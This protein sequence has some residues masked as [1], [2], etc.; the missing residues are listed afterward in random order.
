MDALGMV[1]SIWNNNTAPGQRQFS[2]RSD[3][4]DCESPLSMY[5]SSCSM[6]LRPLLHATVVLAQHSALSLEVL[7]RP[8]PVRPIYNEHSIHTGVLVLPTV[9]CISPYYNL[10]QD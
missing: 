3:V 5:P 9:L 7:I 8:G 2:Q 1:P 10:H 4:S 6:P